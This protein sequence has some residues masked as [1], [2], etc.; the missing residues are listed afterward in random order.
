VAEKEKETYEF[1]VS[2]FECCF[3][4]AVPKLILFFFL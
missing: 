3:I 2:P 4:S 1:T